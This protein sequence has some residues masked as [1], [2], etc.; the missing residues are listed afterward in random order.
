MCIRDRNRERKRKF[1]IHIWCKA[2]LTIEEA[3]AYSGIG[4]AKLDEM[5]ESEDCPFVLSIGSRRNEALDHCQL[6]PQIMALFA[7]G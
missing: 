2:N 1:D 7:Q 6:M 5:T 3:A 4:M